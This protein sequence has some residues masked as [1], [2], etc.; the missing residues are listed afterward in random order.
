M[1]SGEVAVVPTGL[2]AFSLEGKRALITGSARGIGFTLARG[3]AEAGAEVIINATTPAN[4]EA[5]AQR[6]R[7]AG[8]RAVA[9]GFDVTQPAAALEAEI[10][11]LEESVGPIDIL[12]NN[13]GITRRHAFTEFPQEDYAAIMA[14]NQTAVYFISQAVARRMAAR[15]AGKIIHIAS[16]QSCLSR[17]STSAYATSKG[18]V[19]MLARAMC[20]ELAARGVQVNAIAPGYFRTE[21]TESLVADEKFTAWLCARTPAARWGDPHELIGAAVFLSSAA[22]NFVNGHTLYVDGGITVAL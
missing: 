5:A 21:L 20:V 11:A 18:A 14:V 3:L 17:P 7:D 6:L 10:S 13:A 1:S 2:A 16:V 15:G 8:L 9:R 19:V 12:I 4:A 22:S